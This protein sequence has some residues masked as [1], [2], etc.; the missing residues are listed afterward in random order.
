MIAEKSSAA[1]AKRGAF[2]LRAIARRAG[3]AGPSLLSM[4]L[5]GQRKL[6][7]DIALRLADALSLKGHGRKLLQALA[8]AETTKSPVERRRAR[9][10]ALELLSR[11]PETELSASQYR[12]FALWYMPVLYVWIGGDDF[13][14]DTKAIALRLGGGVRPSEVETA[15]GDL[16]AIGAIKRNRSRRLVQSMGAVT[17]ADDV[18]PGALNSYYEQMIDRARGALSFPPDMREFSGLTIAISDSALPRVKE[19]IRAFRHELNS[20]LSHDPD[21]RKIYHIGMQVFPVLK[22]LNSK[23]STK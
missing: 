3:L 14:E 12:F 2:G 15:I 1:G 7:P 13:I 6:T 11:H 19:K 20:T 17:T 18:P 23:R 8:Q 5:R 22:D 10:R 21:A 4:V 16:L 9:E